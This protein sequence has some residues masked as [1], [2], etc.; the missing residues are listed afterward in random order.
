MKKDDYD[1]VERMIAG[2]A[3]GQ[4]REILRLIVAALRKISPGE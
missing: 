4:I 2:V 3:D 1:A